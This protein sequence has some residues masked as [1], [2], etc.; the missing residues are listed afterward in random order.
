MINSVVVDNLVRKASVAQ[1]AENLV[2]GFLY[3]LGFLI[4][5]YAA[6]RWKQKRDKEKDED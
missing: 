2:H 4:V 5:L 6:A 1:F 3:T